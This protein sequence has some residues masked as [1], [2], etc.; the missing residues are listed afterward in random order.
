MEYE[1][2][3]YMQLGFYLKRLRAIEKRKHPKKRR[4]VP[5]IGNLADAIGVNRNR[6]S[7]VIHG[8]TRSLNLDLVAGIMM[9][10]WKRGFDTEITDILRIE[11][12]KHLKLSEDKAD[13]TW[14]P[15]PPLTRRQHQKYPGEEFVKAYEEDSP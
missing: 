7:R 10:M 12:P 13:D 11:R 14:L 3:I 6:I 1:E 15:P 4:D 2:I 5:T 9:E 8:H